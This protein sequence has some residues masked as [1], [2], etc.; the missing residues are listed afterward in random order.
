MSIGQNQNLLVWLQN[1]LV[2]GY[3]STLLSLHRNQNHSFCNKQNLVS[4]NKCLH[5]I[6]LYPLIYCT[7]PC[8]QN[9][10]YFFLFFRKV[11]ATRSCQGAWN[12]RH[13][14]RG[15]AQIFTHF[16]LSLAFACSPGKPSNLIP[17]IIFTCE[18]ITIAMASKTVLKWHSL[19]FY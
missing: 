4:V 5:I 1:P 15:K 17:V 16:H 12:V 11:K 8:L 2:P 7:R 19:A 6:V 18:K 14:W 10:H 9:K 13:A 3:Q